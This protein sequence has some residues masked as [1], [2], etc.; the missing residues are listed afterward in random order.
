[1]QNPF[2]DD[3]GDFL[4]LVNFEAQYSLWPSFREIPPGWNRVGPRG[5]RKDC[6]EWIEKNWTDMRPRS[7]VDQM[8][9]ELT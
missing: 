7:L 2:D 1:M 4:V 8:N 6:L 5:N 9:K 3:Q